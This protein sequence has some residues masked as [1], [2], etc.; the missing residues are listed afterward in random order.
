MAAAIRI[1]TV[2]AVVLL[3]SGGAYLVAWLL[4]G[5][6]WEGPTALR[7]PILFGLSTGITLASL[8]WV[9]TGLRP[10]WGDAWLYG[11]LGGALVLEVALIDVQQAR[12]VRSHYN[13][14]TLLDGAITQAMGVLILWAT[15]LIVDLAVRSH[16]ALRFDPDDAWAAR[17]GL[18]LLV[19]G[20]G[21]GIGITVV[22]EAQLARGLAP[23]TFRGQGVLK[24]PHGLPLHAIQV[25]WLQVR[26]LRWLGAPMP[27]R[28]ASITATAVGFAAVTVYGGVQT[29]LGAPRWPPIAASAPWLVLT[30]VAGAAA[31]WLGRP[32]A[33]A[34]PS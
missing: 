33:S 29:F 30:V 18:W 11:S 12:G 1:C 27:R 13:H 6:P 31:L 5:G 3:A 2:C 7:K 10:R 21:L 15:A 4:L 25:L 32:R 22:G 16:R 26:L 34:R 28:C 24:F 17:A 14:D 20:C 19:V 23:E 8:T 9:M